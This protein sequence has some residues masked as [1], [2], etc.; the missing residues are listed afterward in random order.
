MA[1][2]EARNLLDFLMDIDNY[3][4]KDITEYIKKSGM[5]PEAGKEKG[6]NLIK[7]LEAQEKIK[8]GKSNQKNFDD[9]LISKLSQTISSVP[10]IAY[11]FRNGDNLSEEDKQKMQN[12]I[13]KLEL[14]KKILNRSKNNT[15][16][17]D[18]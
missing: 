5:N 8:S 14:A 3:T 1:Q 6:L 13:Q 9:F 12:D 7:K 10:A 15:E 18:E 2:R 4:D 11:A 17:K 16:D